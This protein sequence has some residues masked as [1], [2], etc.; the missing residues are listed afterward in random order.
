MHT[1]RECDEAIRML[2]LIAE[3]DALPILEEM[4]ITNHGIMHS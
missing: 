1:S 4:V 2:H 3:S